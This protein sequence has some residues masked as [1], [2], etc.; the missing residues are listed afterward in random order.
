MDVRGA[1]AVALQNLLTNA[2]GSYRCVAGT[3]APSCVA[4]RCIAIRRSSTFRSREWGMAGRHAR[5]LYMSFCACSSSTTTAS[6]PTPS[7]F[8]FMGCRFV[9]SAKPERDA[10]ARYSAGS[11][12]LEE[13]SAQLTCPTRRCERGHRAERRIPL[14]Q[15]RDVDPRPGRAGADDCGTKLA[16][17]L[18]LEAVSMAPS[19]TTHLHDRCEDREPER[20]RGARDAC[21]SIWLVRATKPL[22]PSLLIDRRQHVKWG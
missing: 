11:D 8:Y 1:A 4:P 13:L 19:S 12:A 20:Y 21:R 15:H 14:Q 17:A 2:E 3:T 6:M 10:A 16:W 5:R 7:E 18:E 9:G 22:R